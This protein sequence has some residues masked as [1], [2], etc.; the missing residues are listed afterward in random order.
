M[1]PKKNRLSRT[2]FDV[3]NSRVLTGKTVTIR[4]AITEG[5]AVQC[6]AVVVGKAVVRSAVKRNR[7]KRRLYHILREVGLYESV[8]YVVFCKKEI[9]DTSYQNLFTE[10]QTLLKKVS[11]LKNG[12][13]RVQ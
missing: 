6:A 10:I 9:N 4:V 2:V 8:R 11:L 13:G 3:C 7:I 5:V 12:S 1:L